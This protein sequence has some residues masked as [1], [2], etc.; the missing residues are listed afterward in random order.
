MYWERHEGSR[1]RGT[2]CSAKQN[3][4]TSDMVATGLHWPAECWQEDSPGS[5]MAKG[6]LASFQPLRLAALMP[7][8]VFPSFFSREKTR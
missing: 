2:S 4:S 3:N 1:L 7:W 5:P 6:M 8:L